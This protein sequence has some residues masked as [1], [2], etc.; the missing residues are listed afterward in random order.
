MVTL[1]GVGSY[2]LN[3]GDV[4]AFDA[5]PIDRD[6]LILAPEIADS[7]DADSAALLRPSFDALWNAAGL[8]RCGDYDASGQ[9]A[10]ALLSQI[11]RFAGWQDQR[12]SHIE[13]LHRLIQTLDRIP[14]LRRRVF[15]GYITRES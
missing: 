15:V 8:S 9:P 1:L 11:Q 7:Y 2:E 6:A 12:L 5:V 10:R 4:M 14:A 3:T 13:N